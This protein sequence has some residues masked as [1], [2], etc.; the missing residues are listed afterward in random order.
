MKEG[1]FS[2]GAS[3]MG[4][5][6]LGGSAGGQRGQSEMFPRE[7]QRTLVGGSGKEARRR[8]DEEIHGRSEES[9]AQSVVA[10]EMGG[11][12]EADDWLQ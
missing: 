1:T 4:P 9:D 5:E 8:S 7:G 12:L 10:G 6:H 3:R 11:G 2:L